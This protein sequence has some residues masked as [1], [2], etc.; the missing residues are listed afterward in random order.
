MKRSEKKILTTHV[1]SLPRPRDMLMPRHEHEWRVWNE[2]KLPEHKVLIPRRGPSSRRW[3]KARRSPASA[4]GADAVAED[5]FGFKRL[6]GGATGKPGMLFD[7]TTLLP[8]KQ[9][10]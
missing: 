6:A 7:Y 1:G 9:H 3:W 10:L 2:T 8:E 4:S 5:N